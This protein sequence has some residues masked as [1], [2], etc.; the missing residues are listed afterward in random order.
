ML[1]AKLY[2]AILLETQIAIATLRA[3]LHLKRFRPDQPR[4]P[5]G[6]RDGGQWVQVAAGV[7]RLSEDE[8]DELYKKD[9][10][11]CNMVGLASCHQQAM[12]RYSDCLVGK[13]IRPLSY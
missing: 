11:H 13:T 12:F 1:Q 9:T 7:R 10:F 5:A 3:E 6:N 8:C 4:V 2:R